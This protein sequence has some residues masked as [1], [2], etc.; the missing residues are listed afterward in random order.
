MHCFRYIGTSATSSSIRRLIFS[1]EK[2]LQQALNVGGSSSK[3]DLVTV[4]KYSNVKHLAM[5][6]MLNCVLNFFQL[7]RRPV[8]KGLLYQGFEKIE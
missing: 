8:L 5:L 7:G 4:T 6:S 1:I 2:Q 3:N